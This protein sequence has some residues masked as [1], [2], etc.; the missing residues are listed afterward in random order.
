MVY[1]GSGTSVIHTPARPDVIEGM[2]GE[3]FSF[4]DTSAL[5]VWLTAS[6]DNQL[7]F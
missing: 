4:A 1:V 5:N 3:W 6:K 7:S 2:M